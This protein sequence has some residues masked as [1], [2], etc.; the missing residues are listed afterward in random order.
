MWY[1]KII[2]LLIHK[3]KFSG[4]P[5]V[6]RKRISTALN[7]IEDIKV[8]HDPHEDFDIELSTIRHLNIHR[9]PKIL[10]VDGC[11][12]LPQE[13]ARNVALSQAINA[14]KHVI[15]QS[16]YSMCMITHLMGIRALYTIIHNGID[17]EHMD[18][19]QPHKNIIPGSFV[20]SALWRSNKRPHSMIEGFLAADTGRH[21]YVIG[22]NDKINK[23]YKKNSHIHLLG[24]IESQEAISV[25]KACDYQIHLC[26]IDSCP[27][28]VV[29]GLTCGL[30]VLCANLGGTKELVKEDGI[31]LEVD[32]W[33]MRPRKF[34]K[35]DALS[36]EVVASGI[37]SLIEAGN[38]KSHARRE[39]LDINSVAEKYAKVVR[40]SV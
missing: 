7:R 15:Y 26:H 29:E 40:E 5:T 4:G 10:R 39:D 1:L 19:I 17:F 14:S 9:K 33:D 27:N 12:Y 23:R 11:Y 35:L 21:L 22:E 38:D 32:E 28:A 34:K 3:K 13:I 8:I 16:H 18:T 2:R 37:H 6:F 24:K 30:K 36:P 25:M 31:V 20:G